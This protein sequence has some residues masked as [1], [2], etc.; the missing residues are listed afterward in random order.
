MGLVKTTVGERRELEGKSIF[1][2]TN[3]SSA[4]RLSNA[5]VIRNVKG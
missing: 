5:L 2:Q 4:G 3:P 1:K